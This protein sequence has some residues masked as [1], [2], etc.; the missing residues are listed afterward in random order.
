VKRG[1][2]NQRV[3][4]VA[5]LLALGVCAVAA[6]ATAS[7]GSG[8]A[9][10]AKKLT[11]YSIAT[12]EQFLN[13]EDDRDRGKGNNPF[14]NF[15]DATSN[16]KETGV[17]PFAGD[18]AVFTF[19]LYGDPSLRRAVGSA[20]FIC[21]YGF[22]KN[23]FCNASYQLG[24]SQLVGQGAFNFSASSFSLVIVGGTGKYR[25]MTGNLNASPAVQHSQR[26][27]FVFA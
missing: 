18:R 17:G 5:V 12:Q 9:G 20:V 24:K 8:S 2:G 26:L 27:N 10:K 22:D 21:Q 7:L 4:R 1:T 16:A 11:L 13:H 25:G 14:G 23:A 15:R 6:L 3:G 19:K